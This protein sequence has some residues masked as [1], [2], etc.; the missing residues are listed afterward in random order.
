VDVGI[1]EEAAGKDDGAGRA[2]RAHTFSARDFYMALQSKA[3]GT[4]LL[5]WQQ[6]T[7]SKGAAIDENVTKEV[8]QFKWLS[9]IRRLPCLQTTHRFDRRKEFHM[10]TPVS[11]PHRLR[12]HSSVRVECNFPWIARKKQQTFVSESC[13]TTPIGFSTYKRGEGTVRI[14]SSFERTG[15]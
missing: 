1:A 7:V 10:T 13:S 3:I 14:E 4:K 6:D 12:P 11:S 9:Q 5:Q 2:G 8:H 15:E